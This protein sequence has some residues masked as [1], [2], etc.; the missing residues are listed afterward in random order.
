MNTQPANQRVDELNSQPSTE[1]TDAP[2]DRLGVTSE[3]LLTAAKA[4][5][6]A[7][8]RRNNMVTLSQG[9]VSLLAGTLERIAVQMIDERLMGLQVFAAC[10]AATHEV[11]ELSDVHTY[12]TRV[13]EKAIMQRRERWLRQYQEQSSENCAAGQAQRH[14]G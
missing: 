2:H 9:M 5:R 7:I 6:K 4:L 14:A 3:D 13:V 12:T 1:P 10:I 8:D 11:G